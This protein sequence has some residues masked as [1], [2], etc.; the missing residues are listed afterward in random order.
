M[1]H[2]SIRQLLVWMLA[3]LV[4]AG[5]SLSV[6]QAATVMPESAQM[7]MMAGMDMNSS[8]DHGCKLCNGKT[9][10]GKAMTCSAGC[11]IPIGAN[12]W[13]TAI[14]LMSRPV[15]L[16]ALDNLPTGKPPAP[17]PYPPRPFDIV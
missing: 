7:T 9:D 4:T 5:L 14:A 16:M 11:A 15:V 2:W 10:A 13:A 17:D 1:A 6:I 3:V 12:Q 8:G